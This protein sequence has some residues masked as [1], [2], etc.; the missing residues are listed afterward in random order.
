MSTTKRSDGPSL[1][2]V[3]SLFF[4]R[5]APLDTRSDPLPDATPPHLS[6]DAACRS[7]TAATGNA[8]D[9]VSDVMRTEL[10]LSAVADSMCLRGAAGGGGGGR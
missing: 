7:A 3:F 9:A 10:R 1:P 8:A 2:L 4:P 6:A 5:V